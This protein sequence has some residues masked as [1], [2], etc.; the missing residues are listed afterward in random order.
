MAK[1]LLD[2]IKKGLRTVDSFGQPVNLYFHG[3]SLHKTAVGGFCTLMTV[4]FIIIM[5]INACIGLAS[6]DNTFASTTINYQEDPPA[7]DLST[8]DFS[9]MW[10]IGLQDTGKYGLN[11]SIFNYFMTYEKNVGKTKIQQKL[12]LKPCTIQDYNNLDEFNTYNLGQKLCPASNDFVVE[13]TFGA[14]IFSFIKINVTTCVNDTNPGITCASPEDIAIFLTQGSKKKIEFHFLNTVV[15]PLNYETPVSY[16]IDSIYWIVSPGFLILQSDVYFRS[17]TLDTFYGFF[18]ETT[19]DTDSMGYL[20]DREDNIYQATATGTEYLNIYIRSG[21][22]TTHILRTY[23]TFLNVLS[24]I[25]GLWNIIHVV[26]G[27]LAAYYREFL[28]NLHI[29]N[30]LYDF[31]VKTVSSIK[32]EKEYEKVSTGSKMNQAGFAN[33]TKDQVKKSLKELKGTRKVLNYSVRETL[34]RM[35]PIKLPADIKT[36]NSLLEIAESHIARDMDISLLLRRIQD[37]E[38]LK[39]VILNPSQRAL[40]DFVPPPL[41]TVEDNVKITK[42]DTTHLELCEDIDEYLTNYQRYDE[43]KQKN[44]DISHNLLA[45][46]DPQ[47][48]EMFDIIDKH[49][50]PTSPHESPSGLQPN[51]VQD[52]SIHVKTKKS[53]VVPLINKK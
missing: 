46:M 17:I 10:S 41:I 7:L 14:D 19:K 34:R 21:Y 4:I 30:F 40:F 20:K 15:N 2:K 36:K 24:Q 28:F 29:S 22:Y 44:D 53:A 26:L 16:F 18:G 8:N 5:F 13:G 25:G 48:K 38:K 45:L 35:I 47:I 32:K 52:Y 39:R 43:I 1:T 27:F 50:H 49:Y 31:T 11:N 9:F 51:N 37:I 33:N 6:K 42:Q 23:E 12:A 3:E